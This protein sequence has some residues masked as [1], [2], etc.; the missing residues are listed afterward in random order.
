MGDRTVV[1]LTGVI[2]QLLKKFTRGKY[3]VHTFAFKGLDGKEY[4]VESWN[5]IDKKFIGQVVSFDTNFDAQYNNYMLKGFI[6]LSNEKVPTAAPQTQAQEAIQDKG[7][8]QSTGNTTE[9]SGTKRRTRRTKAETSVPGNSVAPVI[10][11]AASVGQ[12]QAVQGQ[13]DSSTLEAFRGPAE[14]VVARNLEFART[15]LGQ[16]AT[17]EAVAITAQTLQAAM[18]TYYIEANKQRRVDTWRS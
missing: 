14:A 3:E 11:H 18:V 8:T 15:Q 17:S 9:E 1:K 10:S 5:A 6:N 4:T 7:Y 2:S 13:Q 16:Q 12:T